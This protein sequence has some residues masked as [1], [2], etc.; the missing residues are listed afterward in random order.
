MTFS[1]WKPPSP[2]L[3][4][5]LLFLSQWNSTTSN[6]PTTIASN[7]T[8]SPADTIVINATLEEAVWGCGAGLDPA[9]RYLCDR[10]AVWG[11]VLEALAS[12]GFL[13]SAGLLL[14]LLLWALC[15]CRR[16]TKGSGLGGTLA[17]MT[18][19]LMATA[20]LFALTFA[21]IVR[22]GPRTCPVRLFLFGVLFAL[23]FG[24]LLARAMALLGFAAA[25]G[26]GEPALALGLFTVQVVI[27]TEWLLVVLVRDGLPCEYSQE[28]FVMLQ[29]YVL[30][31]LAAALLLSL[32]AVCRSCRSYGYTGGNGR[33][34]GRN[35]AAMLF[36][37]VLLSA[38]IWVVW[39]VMMTWGNGR[40]GRRPRWDDP[41]LS[42]VLVANGW[43]FLMGHGLTRVTLFCQEEAQAKEGPLSFAGWTSPNAE[44][45]GLSSVKEGRENGSFENDVGT[46]KGRRQGRGAGKGPVR[47]P[48]LKSPYESGFSMSEIDPERDYTIPR[49]Q[50]TNTSQPLLIQTHNLD[51]L[52]DGGSLAENELQMKLLETGGTSG[53]NGR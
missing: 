13:L 45:P 47:E 12:L 51:V 8:S 7:T 46:G 17:A 32:H 38:A 36:L 30:C 21:F 22:L 1:S 23:A 25:R 28:E 34:Q 24:C 3:L 6:P 50:T 4:L 35:A 20:G 49:P 26:W 11:V 31:L 53:E 18:L 2:P 37:T 40:I 39:I 29:I 5:L 10:H 41:V 48:T 19:F 14:G 43:V 52:G 44:I 42:V 15:T 16:R 9:Y 33:W 27:G